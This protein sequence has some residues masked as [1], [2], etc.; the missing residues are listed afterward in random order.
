MEPCGYFARHLHVH[1]HRTYLLLD[2]LG[3]KLPKLLQEP[4]RNL[5]KIPRAQRRERCE[6]VA[7]GALGG[8]IGEDAG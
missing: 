5:H 7:G 1:A 2:S 8:S 3:R 4:L 6:P